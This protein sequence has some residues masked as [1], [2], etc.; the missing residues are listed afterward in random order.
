MAHRNAEASQ[1][2]RPFIHRW[3]GRF[4]LVLL[5][6]I[7][8][9]LA[10]SPFKQFY[11]A[12]I[13][14]IPWLWVVAEAKSTRRAVLWSWLGG[15]LFFLMN[16]WWL[17]HV[18]WPGM[19]GLMVVQGWY[20]WVP[21]WI[22]RSFCGAGFQPASSEQAESPHYNDMS[23]LG[24]VKF[25]LGM[26]AVWTTLEW[27]RGMMFTGFPWLYLGHSQ[28]PLLV[29]C[30]IADVFGVFGVTFCVVALNALLFLLLRSHRKNLRPAMGVV[31]RL[32]T[33][34]INRTACCCFF[35]L[36]II[37]F[38]CSVINVA[39]VYVNFLMVSRSIIK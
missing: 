29:V 35:F 14:L 4:A 12:W 33:G 37:I 16:E 9:T 5:S 27:I 18:S 3:Y 25:I 31:L 32:L 7:L 10:F 28:T 30:Q 2:V 22:I 13:G 34:C 1:T 23:V 6:V 38:F 26:A 36:L 11:L 15:T 21:A 39:M 24:S 19:L 20:W 17:G 8:L